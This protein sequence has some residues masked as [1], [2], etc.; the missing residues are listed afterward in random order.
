MKAKAKKVQIPADDKVY[1]TVIYIIMILFILITLLPLVNIVACSFSSGTMVSAG[2]V[3]FWPKQFSLDSYKAVFSYR[4]VPRAFLN[5]VFYT[6]VGTFLKLC[7][8]MMLA[9]PL[10]RM[11]VPG[12]AI[13]MVYLMIPNYFGGG[14]IPTYIQISKL[15]MINTVWSIILPTSVPIT[16]AIITRTFIRGSIGTE[17]LEAA[18]LDGAS[19]FQFFFQIVLPL[20]KVIIATDALFYIS[21][22]WNSYLSAQ[23]Y[24]RNMDLYPLQLVLKNVLTSAQVTLADLEKP[25]LIAG[26]A[27][28]A[29]L[30]KYAFCVIAA[31]P[32]MFVYPFVQKYLVQG[33]MVGATKG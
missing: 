7:M 6:V 10:S 3:T 13:I 14:M 28:L 24:L 15:G 22:Y 17:M 30:L 21:G 33:V 12:M 8:T 9:Y 2:R 19:D 26:R 29:E 18:K 4:G 1:Y 27:G 20:S 31:L 25:D 11:R 23:L 16:Q 5:S 32:M